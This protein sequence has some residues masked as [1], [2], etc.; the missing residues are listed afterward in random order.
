MNT[1]AHRTT[2]TM[3]P[4]LR[5]LAVLIAGLVLFGAIG[6]VTLS[7]GDPIFLP[8][9]LLLGAAIVPVT[10]S[11]FVSEA[12]PTHLSLAS[13][14]TAAVLGGVLGG[15]LA[16]LLEFDTARTLGGLPFSMVAVI[17]ECAKLAVLAAFLVWRHPRLRTV[18]GLV[19]GVAVGS[20]FAAVETMGYGFVML[21]RTGGNLL[22]VDDL[23]ALRALSSLGGHAAWTG[24]ACAA[25]FAV[26]SARRRALGWLRF[27]AVLI[28]V[29]SLHAG[30]DSA[31][32]GGYDDL[33][34]GLV[35]FAA[36]MA[37]TWSLRR[38]ARGSLE[39]PKGV[40]HSLTAWIRHAPGAPPS[41]SRSLAGA[42]VA[43]AVGGR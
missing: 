25:L 36:L 20:A 28:G 11:T 29:I 4:R 24:L 5:W 39:P 6:A 30:W 16:G 40:D 7:T 38:A 2:P 14:L 15:I 18:D 37:L 23:L 12:E 32:G 34:L 17:E 10:L 41:T 19:L 26:P 8:C 9:L 33:A 22:S 27:F 43:G 13:I 31:A 35:S 1:V 3:P 42:P 21:L